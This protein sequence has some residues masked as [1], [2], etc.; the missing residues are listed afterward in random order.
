M[1]WLE[2]NTLTGHN[3]NATGSSKKRAKGSSR[4][5]GMLEKGL[6]RYEEGFAAG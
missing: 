1:V 3:P 4:L 2:L 5:G 6:N